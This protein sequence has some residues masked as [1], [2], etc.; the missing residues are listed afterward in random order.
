MKSIRLELKYCEYCGGLLLRAAG[1]AVIYCAACSRKIAELPSYDDRSGDAARSSANAGKSKAKDQEPPSDVI[2]QTGV[3]PVI[4]AKAEAGS[5]SSQ[6]LDLQAV[7]DEYRG[8]VD[9]VLLVPLPP[10]SVT[11]TD[12]ECAPGRVG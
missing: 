6:T 11:L 8:S 9:N 1:D 10:R 12:A 7:A 4:D 2:P 3:S 5:P